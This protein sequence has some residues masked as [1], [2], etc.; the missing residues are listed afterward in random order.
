MVFGNQGNSRITVRR[1]APQGA[2]EPVQ[3]ISGHLSPD[4]SQFSGS[5][6]GH[7][8]PGL[9]GPEFRFSAQQCRPQAFA[10]LSN[11]FFLRRSNFLLPS[12]PPVVGVL[13]RSPKGRS[14]AGARGGQP[15]TDRQ[16]LGATDVASPRRLRTCRAPVISGRERGHPAGRECSSAVPSTTAATATHGYLHYNKM[17]SN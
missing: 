13:T 1:M 17:K 16:V 6:S 14:K 2:P 11:F 10:Y 7:S 12:R 8:P 5:C 9:S 3:E 15:N 4:T